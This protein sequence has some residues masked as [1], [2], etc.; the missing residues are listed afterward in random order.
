MIFNEVYLSSPYNL[1]QGKYYYLLVSVEIM[2]H[3][4]G[5]MLK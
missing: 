2:K 4:Q 1:S 3:S 5:Y